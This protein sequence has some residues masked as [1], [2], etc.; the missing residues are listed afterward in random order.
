MGAEV[1]SVLKIKLGE[2]TIYIFLIIYIKPN[3][4]VYSFN[5]FLHGELFSY[6][7]NQKLQ[8]EGIQVLF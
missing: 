1:V 8:P 6:N 7:K 4:Y 2:T 5:T 3:K